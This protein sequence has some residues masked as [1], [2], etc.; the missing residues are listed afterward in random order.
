MK[1]EQ[2]KPSKKNL[3][4]PLKEKAQFGV[5]ASDTQKYLAEMQMKS[6]QRVAQHRRKEN[7]KVANKVIQD[8]C[9]KR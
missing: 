3:F 1:I 8:Q 5:I 2:S 4:S 9:K 6:A 7:D